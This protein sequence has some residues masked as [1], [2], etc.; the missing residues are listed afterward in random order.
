MALGHRIRL[1]LAAGTALALV[2]L[3]SP[4]LAMAATDPDIRVRYGRHAD[5]VRIVFHWQK[6]TEYAV[7]LSPEGA[8]IVFE[9]P[10]GFDLSQVRRQP[11]V[12]AVLDPEGGLRIAYSRARSVKHFRHGSYVVVDLFENDVGEALPDVAAAE[13]AADAPVRLY[14]PM[15]PRRPP[16]N[17]TADV[18]AATAANSKTPLASP[19]VDAP[20]AQPPPSGPIDLT[21][22][23]PDALKDGLPSVETP[24]VVPPTVVSVTNV[25][26]RILIGIEVPNLRAAAY[27]RAGGHWII[28][29][30]AL[31]LDL[32]GLEALNLEPVLLPAADMT[33]IQMRVAATPELSAWREGDFWR[34]GLDADP[35]AAAGRPVAI[36]RRRGRPEGP[37]LELTQFGAARLLRVI[38]PEVGD[39]LFVAAVEDTHF[40]AER[41]E[42]PDAILPQT[43]VGVVIQ[44]RTEGVGVR[45]Q[46]A[47][48]VVRKRGGLRMSD[49]E[50]EISG[51]SRNRASALKLAA[52]RG[53]DASYMV[54]LENRLSKLNGVNDLGRNVFRMELA[55]FSMAN[56]YAAEAVGY[57]QSIAFSDDGADLAPEFRLLR[58]ASRAMLGQY[59]LAADDLS[60]P[61]FSGDPNA[62]I[63]RAMALADRGE[64]R[65]AAAKF[66]QYWDAIGEWPSIQRARFTLAA[67]EAALIAGL[68]D[69]AEG[70]LSRA[71]AQDSISRKEQAASAFVAGGVMALRGDPEAAKQRFMEAKEVGGRDMKV[72]T[73]LALV[74]IDYASGAI[75]ADA[76]SARLHRLQRHW[77]GDRIEYETLKTLGEIRLAES[78]FRDGFWALREATHRFADRYDTSDVRA[79]LASGFKRAFIDGAADGMEPLEAVALFQDYR[80]LAPPGDLGDRALAN[81]AGRLVALDLVDEADEIYDHLVRYRLD[82]APRVDTAIALSKLRVSR[83]QWTE[84]LDALDLVAGIDVAAGPERKMLHL[85]AE[86][87]AGA[88]Q[89]DEG[90]ALLANATDVESQ[91][92][93]SRIAWRAGDWISAR[94]AYRN[95]ASA[96]VFDGEALDEAASAQV[97]RWAVAATM[98]RNISEAGDLNKRFGDRIADVRLKSALAALATPNAGDGEALAAARTALENVSGLARAIEGY[99]AAGQSQG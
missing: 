41:V 45:L 31:D 46:A 29:D 77:R 7:E 13:A 3:T 6:R 2:A 79:M 90:L 33:I 63:W 69:I 38:D 47:S 34:F 54:G 28:L 36:E 94:M 53:S 14:P 20:A 48:M 11:G 85:R 91:A 78:G 30:R 9:A 82:G 60:L 21:A 98:L 16:N 68:P 50:R 99:Q 66:R 74:R 95:L 32:S 27:T 19:K 88:G 72:R 23:A 97:V 25:G 35:Q 18:G 1:G 71:P 62:E 76:A 64:F 4:M 59:D 70:F 39:A 37:R 92:L 86:A 96:G 56:G 80:D 89:P 55:R 81:F 43:A 17:M 87:L 26:G 15:P 10:N 8:H 49:P 51:G 52:W 24:T 73:E 58:G 40:V 44:P 57:L 42:S 61:A 12:Q 67:G 5:H 84:A 75:D 65:L 22:I 93:R 83:R